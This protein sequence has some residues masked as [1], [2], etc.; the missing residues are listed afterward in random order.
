[1][2]IAGPTV[3]R[4]LTLARDRERRLPEPTELVDPLTGREMEVLQLMAEG[5]DTRALAER[6]VLGQTTVRTHVA[7]ILAKLEVHSRLE[8][9]VKATRLNLLP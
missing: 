7:A 5:L 8:A 4:L 1:M 2:L 6:L 3:A 9:V